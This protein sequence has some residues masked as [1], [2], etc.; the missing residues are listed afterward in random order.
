MPHITVELSAIPVFRSIK[1]CVLEVIVYPDI[2]LSELI[3]QRLFIERFFFI[4][5][6]S[7]GD[8]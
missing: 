7:Q 4:H 5:L 3:G 8:S 1:A 6:E 2:V